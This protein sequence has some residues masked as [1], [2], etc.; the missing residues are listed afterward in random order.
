MEL[1]TKNVDKNIDYNNSNNIILFKLYLI[2]NLRI[3]LKII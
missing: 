2:K 1:R 3:K